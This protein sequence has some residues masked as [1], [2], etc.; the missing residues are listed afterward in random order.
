MEYNYILIYI[1]SAASKGEAMYI[2]TEK[3]LKM[4]V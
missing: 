2:Y 1:P 4:D 3:L